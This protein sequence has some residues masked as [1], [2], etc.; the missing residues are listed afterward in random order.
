M[1]SFQELRGANWMEKA[2]AALGIEGNISLDEL[3]DL[4]DQGMK[5]HR[6]PSMIC[7]Y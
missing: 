2:N 5:L 6:K 3:R 4:I 7:F 1:K